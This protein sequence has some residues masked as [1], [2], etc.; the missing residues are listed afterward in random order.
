MNQ[1][2]LNI[3]LLIAFVVLIT[4]SFISK[5]FFRKLQPLDYISSM[6]ESVSLTKQ[7]FSVIEQLKI[8][9]GIKSGV[10]SNVPFNYMIGDEWSEITT[11]LGSLEAKETSTN[12]DFSALIVRLL[13][14]A[15]IT[16]KDK[17]GVIFS[18][19]F[20]SL[21]VAVL[22]G[23]Q[24]MGLD[25]LVMSSVGAST[26]GANQ[27]EATW[28]DMESALIEH[29]GLKYHSSIVSAGAGEDEGEGLSEEGL[30]I[31]RYTAYR[32][33]VNLYSPGSLRESIDKRVEVFKEANI[34]ILINIGGS[35][36]ALGECPHS[37]SIPNGFHKE[38]TR[39]TDFD[40]G[41]IERMNELGVPFINFLDI[42]DLASQYGIDI[43][44][45]TK[46]DKS[47]IL[48]N[49]RESNKRVMS[50]LFVFSIIP[51]YFLRKST[52]IK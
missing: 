25:A 42:K 45:G 13:H 47:I 27:P 12:P 21:A 20:P 46:Y 51:L 39:C 15:G 22:A 8:E 6:N 3:R 32:N 43:S 41:L 33:K 48:F 50:I 38:L 30:S 14:E 1:L 10:S 2:K 31:V 18:G 29:G 44:P 28:L 16:K 23:L 19:S 4:C 24:T 5:S 26:Y 7:W 34:S 9:K 40:R 35:Q 17:V 52:L 11:T 36:T 37:L 49:K